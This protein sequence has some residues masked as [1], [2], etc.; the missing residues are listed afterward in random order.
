MKRENAF[1]PAAHGISPALA[2][3]STDSPFAI[4]VG[5]GEEVMVKEPSS[6]RYHPGT[7][8]LRGA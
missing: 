6:D 7:I 2:G 5:T 8:V 1:P 4:T 3:T